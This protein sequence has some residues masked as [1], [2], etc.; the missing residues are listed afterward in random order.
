MEKNIYQLACFLQNE[1]NTNIIS[2]ADL[3]EDIKV[4]KEEIL[5]LLAEKIGKMAAEDKLNNLTTSV[6]DQGY[7]DGIRA[8]AQLIGLITGDTDTIKITA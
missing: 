2:T 6:Y 8:G 7:I 5:S 4:A 1:E 3:Q